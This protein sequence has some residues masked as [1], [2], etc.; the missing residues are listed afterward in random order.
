M[1]FPLT[2]LLICLLI[3]WCVARSENP[4]EASNSAAPTPSPSASLLRVNVSNQGYNFRLPW[5]R[6]DPAGKRG[7]GA[8]LDDH[9]V[10]VTA[11]L[12]A[13]AIYIDFELPASGRKLTAQV[14][15]IDYE[16]NLAV[17]RAS[18]EPDTFFDGLVPLGIGEDSA[19]GETL[20]VW[21]IE[22][23][24][25]PVSTTIEISQVEIGPYFVPGHYL[26]QYKASGN[27]QYR[28]GTFT[29][30]VVKNGN[31]AGV[32]FR[33][34]SKDEVSTI[35]PSPI[36][37]NFLAD[38]QDGFYDGFPNLGIEYAQTL[39]EQ[40]R[41]FLKL[42]DHTGA[43][44]SSVRPGTSAETAGILAG[45]VIIS[46]DGHDI[47]ARGNYND[48]AYG[49]LNFSHLVRGN[50]RVGDSSELVVMRAGKPR[51][52]TVTLQRKPAHAYLVDPY[53]FD[54][55]GNYLLMGGLLFQELSRPY[56]ESYGSKWRTRAPFKLVYAMSHPEK[57]ELQGRR[58]L[59]F[60]AGTLPCQSVQGYESLGGIIVDSVNGR[61]INDIR[62]LDI[63]FN[64]PAEGIHEI[65]FEDLPKVIWLDDELAQQDNFL[66]IP[67]R[68]QITERM[69]LE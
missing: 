53:I 31:I 41:S 4:G 54:R 38:A 17:L 8:L 40:F 11:E 14:E 59:V 35:I 16:S 49:L 30:P 37:R 6:S 58:K 32:L 45:D 66:H 62:D 2:R 48:P 39:D 55:G 18:D 28:A 15:T 65:R 21:Q 46:I 29:L 27:V 69:R 68:Y 50:A 9:R 44:I 67:Q 5:Q 33:Y 60:L 12:V 51:T 36:I 10:L 64:Y 7:L 52:I 42:G 25:S 13:D 3:P 23:N 1:T 57:Y 22:P 56:L 26:L 20:E 19:I 47:D 43:Y 61:S 24:G 63:A 34:S